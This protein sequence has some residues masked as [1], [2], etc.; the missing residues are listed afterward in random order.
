MSAESEHAAEA[1]E[2]RAENDR[3][4]D[5]ISDLRK[6]NAHLKEDTFSDGLLQRAK[7]AEAEVERL[8][9][10]C[11]RIAIENMDHRMCAEKA[12]AEVERLNALQDVNYAALQ[13]ETT[14]RVIAEDQAA[15]LRAALVAVRPQIEAPNGT[16]AN[17]GDWHRARL[18]EIDAALA[19]DAGRTVEERLEL[20][21]D[22][23]IDS[24]LTTIDK[25]VGNQARAKPSAGRNRGG[26]SISAG[27][28]EPDPEATKRALQ[29]LGWLSPEQAFDLQAEVASLRA[30]M[31]GDWISG[32]QVT[33]LKEAV[34]EAC[35]KEARCFGGNGDE[36]AKAIRALDLS[37]VK[38]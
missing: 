31:S 1:R 18:S 3:L 13:A 30:A 20:K 19:T 35:A 22:Q 15:A 9:A 21:L 8:Q 37:Q 14:K 24:H 25:L 11:T 33:A 23:S 7:R 26:V 34:R 4:H 17:A 6:E 29:V 36:I 5:T 10:D 27:L 12:E 16:R 32:E 2:L 38:P 28:F